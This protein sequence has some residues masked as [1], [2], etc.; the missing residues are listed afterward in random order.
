MNV[1]KLLRLSAIVLV[2]LTAINIVLVVHAFSPDP[3]P[4]PEYS[5][6]W[7]VLYQANEIGKPLLGDHWF[8]TDPDP[9]ILEAI[10]LSSEPEIYDPEK[11]ITWE[12]RTRARAN[13][14]T[15]IYQVYEH[16]EMWNIK[17]EAHYYCV[18]C[19]CHI[20][21]HPEPD[22]YIIPE[23]YTLHNARHAKE[24]ALLSGSILGVS[25]LAL[26]ALWIAKKPKP[27]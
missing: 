8:L 5:S 23:I 25:W 3:L 4:F 1:M 2:M 21:D 26:G 22:I 19:L 9:Y 16:G 24:L 12:H 20:D 11:H 17:Y 18:D 14:T 6:G 15:F 10:A 13:E 7:F 27:Q